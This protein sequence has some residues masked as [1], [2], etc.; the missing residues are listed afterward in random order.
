MS[1][2]MAYSELAEHNNRKDCWLLISG[3][4][5]DVTKFLEDHPGGDEVI[6]SAT[7]KDATDDF[8]DVGHSS[9]ARDMMHSYYIGEV[10]S[11]TLPA[12]PTFK[13]ATQDAYNPDKTSQF[14]IKILQFLVPL[15]I[16]GLA[17]AVRFFTKQS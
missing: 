16:L 15:A 13:L 6:L 8:E 10:D 5:Y 3:K 7:G 1:K 9:S 4:I 12:K 11:A 17:V 2:I 14:L